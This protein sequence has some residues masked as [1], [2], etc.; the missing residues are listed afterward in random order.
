MNNILPWQQ[1]VW[2]ALQGYISSQRIPQAILLSGS[3]GLGIRQLADYYAAG[4]LCLAPDASRQACGHCTACKLL[5]A[6][7]H[8]DYQVLAPD[9]PGKA[10]GIDKIRQLIVKLALKPQFEAYRLVIIEPAEQL[11][12]AAANAFLKCLEEPTERT[13]F[14]LIS[15]QP[16]KLPATIRSR[17]QKIACTVP[18]TEQAVQ[19]L[20][21][22]G[23]GD[24]AGL[25]LRIAG[26][27]PL[28]AKQYAERQILP[29]RNDYF[30]SW[31]QIA[32]GKG[33]PL[34]LADQWQKQQ[35]VELSIL[36][37]WQIS[38]VTDIIKLIQQADIAD[39]DNQD[40]NTAL[41][42]LSSKLCLQS[43]FLFYDKLL[44]SR[45]LLATQLNRQLLLEQTLIDWLQ[46]NAA[47]K[48]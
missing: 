32:M 37:D 1:T 11:N 15:G 7:T 12:V 3:A 31:L 45:S 19:W 22:Q 6:G 18:D 4:L 28:L 20:R 5:A 24:E 47:V 29:L 33:N 41:R 36:F 34:P 43:V 46:L 2:Q 25:L 9:E 39:L 10:I 44:R 21:Q 14:I 40:L 30:H 23:L 13:C 38:W 26:G 8:A 35:D 27:A 16:S 42:Q 48:L 17:C